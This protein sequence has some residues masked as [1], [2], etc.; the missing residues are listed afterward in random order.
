[1]HMG[2]HNARKDGELSHIFHSALEALRGA[3]YYGFDLAALNLDPS[4]LQARA[5][6]N[7]FAGEEPGLSHEWRPRYPPTAQA[8]AAPLP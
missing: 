1:M 3:I 7:T 2:I 4:T 8:R 6:A 5:D